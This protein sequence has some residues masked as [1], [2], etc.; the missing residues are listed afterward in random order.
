M[1]FVIGLAFTM[2]SGCASVIS[3]IDKV[4]AFITGTVVPDA[5]AAATYYQTYI[6]GVVTG[7]ANIPQ[8]K[9]AVTPTITKANQAVATLQGYCQS[10]ALNSTVT[11]GINSIDSLVQEINAIVGA[12]ITPAP[13]VTPAPPS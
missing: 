13:A 4:D 7:V 9:S 8:L 10:G 5:C 3:A 12:V 11:S 1:L 2:V 6:Q